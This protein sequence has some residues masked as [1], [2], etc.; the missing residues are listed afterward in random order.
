M[1][2]TKLEKT[3]RGFSIAKFKDRNN[4]ECSLQKSSIATE[5]CIWFGADKLNLRHFKAGQGWRD[6]DFPEDTIQE[7]YLANTRM[8]LSQQTV[9]DLLPALQNFAETGELYDIDDLPKNP[10]FELIKIIEE[11][12]SITVIP[13][14][15]RIDGDWAVRFIWKATYGDKIFENKEWT[16]FYTADSAILDMVSVLTKDADEQR[17]TKK[18]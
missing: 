3:E 13:Q 2:D 6:V 18:N 8:H 1:V 11:G 7:H 5:D 4:E 17:K 15:K 14:P 10:S 12:Y 9:R 16:G